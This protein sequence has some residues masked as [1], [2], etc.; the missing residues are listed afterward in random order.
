MLTTRSLFAWLVELEGIDSSDERQQ[1]L[2]SGYALAQLAALEGRIAGDEQGHGQLAMLLGDL[3]HDGWIN[4]D[5]QPWPND[6][7]PSSGRMYQPQHLQR[8]DNVRVTPQGLSA[9]HARADLGR[10]SAAHRAEVAVAQDVAPLD[11]NPDDLRD[12]FV[13]HAS[14]N[15]DEIARPLVEALRDRGHSTW[16][17]EAELMLGSSLSESIDWGL[18]HSRFGVVILSR[19]FFSKPWPRRELQGLVAREMSG[20]ERLILPVWHRVDAAYVANVSP[21]LA[22][23]L[24]AKTE[25]GIEAVADQISR[26][27][28]HRRGLERAKG[29]P[30]PARAPRQETNSASRV[31]EAH[32]DLR[33]TL[34]GL[35]RAGDSVGAREL[36]RAERRSWEVGVLGALADAGDVMGRNIDSPT[37]QALEQRLWLFVERRLATL[38]PLVEYD[39][40]RLTEELD[41]LSALAERQ[42][43]TKSTAQEWRRGSRVPVWMVVHVLGAWA[44]AQ[45]AWTVVRA[46]WDCRTSDERPLGV[47]R[48]G[49]ATRLSEELA[50]A[51]PN[52]SISSRAVPLWHL[53]FRVAASDF[54]A[55]RYS[56]LVQ[57]SD[58][59]DPVLACLSRVGDF[60]WLM[61]GLAGQ[62]E[63]DLDQWWRAG[64]VSLGLPR[65]VERHRELAEQLAR[66]LFRDQD[67]VPLMSL[68]TW[69]ERAGGTTTW[70]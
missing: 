7:E 18:A 25:S 38:L 8:M 1:A 22:D 67:F 53:G 48:Q 49:R 33:D 4:W 70:D 14:E 31:D 59:D 46:I 56:E 44:T 6:R 32:V 34:V 19:E 2:R 51:R 28:A 37:M 12:V 30:L 9:H 62:A 43:P 55:E 61:T 68:G 3:R 5:W 41:A 29:H 10:G 11:E 57:T 15:K 13:S 65:R 63:Q 36:L 52:T 66:E 47:L 60:S 40:D 58:E 24:A 50:R 16:F 45:R 27:I 21:P 35:I 26:A 69:I 54:L 64:Q 23:L 17:D 42:V 20:G 39:P